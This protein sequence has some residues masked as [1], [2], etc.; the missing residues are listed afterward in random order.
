HNFDWSRLEQ[1]EV[2]QLSRTDLTS[3]PLSLGKAPYLR[4]LKLYRN[5]IEEFPEHILGLEKLSI[6]DLSYNQISHLPEGIG[7]MRSLERLHLE[8]NRISE[9]PE[10]I[11]NLAD[12][13]VLQIHANN[14]S[15]LPQTIWELGSLQSNEQE[16]K[17]LMGLRLELNPFPFNIPPE[18]YTQYPQAL[19]SHVMAEQDKPKDDRK[20]VHAL[21]IGIDRHLHKDFSPLKGCV[22]DAKKM[23]EALRTRYSENFDLRMHSLYD[24]Q[25]TKEGIVRSIDMITS[26]MITGDTVL[27]YF[28]GHA[29][30]EL[31]ELNWDR[32]KESNMLQG[33]AC[34]DSR[35]DNQG[36]GLL[37]SMEIRYLYDQISLR[38][39]LVIGIFD[40]HYNGLFK[41][42]LEGEGNPLPARAWEDF[43]FSHEKSEAMLQ[44]SESLEQFIPE[45]YFIDLYATSGN[46]QAY[47]DSLEVG[48][49]GGVFTSA[50]LQIMEETDW[51][52][53]Y[54]SLQ[55]RLQEA[56]KDRQQ[57][58]SPIIVGSDRLET[59]LFRNFLGGEELGKIVPVNLI[60]T[61]FSEKWSIDLGALH[62][63][64]M[65]ENISISIATGQGIQ[66]AS[67]SKLLPSSAEIEFIGEIELDTEGSHVG[68]LM[69][70]NK[71]I[72]KVFIG[73]EQA[74]L[75]VYYEYLNR[76]GIEEQIAGIEFVNKREEANY[77]L[78]AENQSYGIISVGD[79]RPVARKIKGYEFYSLDEIFT[80][81]QHIRKWK[82]IQELENPQV[83]NFYL[84]MVEVFIHPEGEEAR[85]LTTIPEVNYLAD[86]GKSYRLEFRNTSSQRVYIAALMMSSQ[87]GV[88]T[89]LLPRMLE[90]EPGQSIF[91]AEGRTFK[92]PIPDH[93]RRFNWEEEILTLKIMLSTDAFRVDIF[94]LEDLGEEQGRSRSRSFLNFDSLGEGGAEWM[95][96]NYGIRI[97]NLEYRGEESGETDTDTPR[98]PKLLLLSAG[99][100]DED[101]LNMQTE[102]RHIYE[103]LGENE[104]R[105]KFSLASHFNVRLRELITSIAS[106][107]PQ[108]LHFTSPGLE[109]LKSKIGEVKLA[110]SNVV[111]PSEPFVRFGIRSE[112]EEGKV[113]QLSEEAISSI[114]SLFEKSLN[115]VVLNGC[116]EE[117]QARSIANFIDILIGIQ[118]E[119]PPEVA[120]AF[121][122]EFYKALPDDWDIPDAFQQ[123]LKFIM[124]EYGDL[125]FPK[126]IL[127]QKSMK[128]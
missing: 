36:V 101:A 125:D 121:I 83:Q 86:D 11:G 9:I 66:S 13:K 28:G 53:S 99:P 22:S 16:R 103:A 128:G 6:L 109:P 3:V 10:S 65:D 17:Y 15:R 38:G 81:F 59:S 93:V 76:E 63:I 60:F 72:L 74:G 111:M 120:K 82:D 49:R 41:T 46:Q 51:E 12:L 102:F 62:G 123:A 29:H 5:E 39:G 57:K 64:T 78:Q 69:G 112:D 110:Q 40:T 32:E 90:L 97:K 80:Q 21:I 88:D 126:P 8:W 77:E 56:L 94:Q 98:T 34:Y 20:V 118:P 87:F 45:S 43:I 4:Q 44:E 73:G 100:T 113:R 105:D 127:L 96:V 31:T 108:I 26:G 79:E 106:E 67:I 50:F 48:Q 122:L 25:A 42:S 47:E 92:L 54:A 7:R 104:Q 27:I 115:A 37:S 75:D 107:T 23:E 30:Y 119:T 71:Q 70:V 58:Q 124:G 14:L 52:I 24:Q 1:L 91:A 85:Q 19:I 55:K 68:M 18:K 84:G 117:R 116:Y 2:L 89:R 95:A 114:F 61:P 35:I 33:L